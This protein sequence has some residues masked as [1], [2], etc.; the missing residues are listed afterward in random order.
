MAGG[1]IHRVRRRKTA[2]ASGDK[3]EE[4]RLAAR[5]FPLS[6]QQRQVFAA[7]VIATRQQNLPRQ[8]SR[9]RQTPSAVHDNETRDHLLS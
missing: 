5:P 8:R 2:A 3:T 9:L 7:D 1:L 6:V 4:P